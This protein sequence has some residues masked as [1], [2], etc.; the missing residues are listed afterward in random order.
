MNEAQKFIKKFD[1]KRIILDDIYH[2][3]DV[4]IS[5][6][7]ELANPRTRL[8]FLDGSSVILS[9]MDRRNIFESPA[10]VMGLGIH[11]ENLVNW[12]FLYKGEQ[13]FVTVQE[14][15]EDIADIDLSRDIRLRI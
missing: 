12:S 5:F 15:K 6:E 4:L 1:K 14:L 11:N 13:S 10:E 7:P 9:P 2:S 3:E 8:E